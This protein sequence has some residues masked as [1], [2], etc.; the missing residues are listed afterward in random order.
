MIFGALGVGSRRKEDTAT[1]VARCCASCV[2]V[3]GRE[4]GAFHC[5]SILVQ[6]EQ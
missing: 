1:A 3:K 6:E 4:K 2:T 5:I